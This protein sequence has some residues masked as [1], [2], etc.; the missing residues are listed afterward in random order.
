MGKNG[1]EPLLE[2]E[3]RVDCL[4]RLAVSSAFAF[5]TSPSAHNLPSSQNYSV[6]PCINTK[7]VLSQVVAYY[8]G[9]TPDPFLSKTPDSFL[10]RQNVSHNP[11]SPAFSPN[12]PYRPSVQT[13]ETDTAAFPRSLY[14]TAAR[15]SPSP[16][17]SSLSA[18][19][20]ETLSGLPNLLL[21]SF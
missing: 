15:R 12:T 21:E 5:S 9:Y 6:Y 13:C 20:L 7:T 19:C 16:L 1:D 4:H 14:F 17:L 10:R 8:P 18:F 2:S 11:C 3:A